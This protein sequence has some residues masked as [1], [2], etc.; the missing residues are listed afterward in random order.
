MNCY[1]P[2]QST[3]SNLACSKT[4]WV[5][6]SCLSGGYSF[7][8]AVAHWRNAVPRGERAGFVGHDGGTF[9]HPNGV[10]AFSPGLRGTSY[11]G[12]PFRKFNNPERVAATGAR[13][14]D[15]TPLGLGKTMEHDPG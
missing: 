6:F 15:A 13:T 12:K 14:I 1:S 5:A 3:Q 4:V 10:T 2:A 11:P 9:V 7:N 8:R